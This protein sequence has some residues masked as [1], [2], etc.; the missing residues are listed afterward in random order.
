MLSARGHE[1]IHSTRHTPIELGK[2]V[3]SID[4]DGNPCAFQLKGNPGGRLTA[5]AFR[6]LIPQLNQLVNLAIQHPAS[7]KQAH[8]S[9]FVTNGVLDED[10]Q[11][12][13]NA[14]NEQHKLLGKG[15]IEV[16]ERGTLLR[17]GNDLGSS[18]WPSEIEELNELLGLLVLDGDGELPIHRIDKLII[19]VLRLRDS[20]KK[21]K[22]DEFRRRVTSCALL[23]GLAVGRFA[24]R[25]N[26]WAV[27][28]AWVLFSVYSIGACKKHK[29][30]FSKNAQAAVDIASDEIFDRLA[31]LFEDAREREYWI[32]GDILLDGLFYS[33]RYLLLNA[34][35]SVLYLWADSSKRDIEGLDELL[36][37]HPDRKHCRLPLW[38]EF[39]VPQFLAIHWRMRKMDATLRPDLFLA[40]LLNGVVESTENNENVAFSGPYDDFAT[41]F[42]SVSSNELPARKVDVP[43]SAPARTSFF[44]EGLLHLL[45]RT[46]MKQGCKVAWPNYSRIGHGRFVPDSPADYCRYR[47]ANGIEIITQQKPTETWD[48]LTIAARQV[49]L[50]NVPNVLAT[51]TFL[52]L[53]YIIICPHRA[54]PSVV[55]FLGRQL[56][57]CWFLEAPIDS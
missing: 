46:G 41:Y 50:E 10:A 43:P 30:G 24:N 31:L 42:R 2:D 33:T 12:S 39:A 16:I 47:T 57:T 14:L 13:L 22:A 23:I 9:Y 15:Q 6:D 40:H 3:I 25:N 38:G 32:E 48:N 52:L 11:L 17:W 19:S 21:L 8:R 36:R 44:A 45:V 51:R 7:P 27:I 28:C 1:V 49:S 54:T 56:N 34:L 35:F 4:P 29:L 18:L 53:L 55:R 5:N 26:H 20:D 37:I